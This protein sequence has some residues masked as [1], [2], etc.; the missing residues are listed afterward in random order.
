V[1]DRGFVL[2]RMLH[3]AHTGEPLAGEYIAISMKTIRLK[4]FKMKLFKRL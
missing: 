2:K 3:A 1:G 4:H